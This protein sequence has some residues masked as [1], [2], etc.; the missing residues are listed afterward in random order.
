[1]KKRRKQTRRTPVEKILISII[2]FLKD[3]GLL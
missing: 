1:M 3:C 2:R